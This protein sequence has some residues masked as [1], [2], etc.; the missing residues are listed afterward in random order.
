MDR[1]NLT[2]LISQELKRGNAVKRNTMCYARLSF[3][4]RGMISATYRLYLPL[5]KTG[6]LEDQRKLVSLLSRK[7]KKKKSVKY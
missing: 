7:E 6:F 3:P 2:A 1:K 5:F 4:F